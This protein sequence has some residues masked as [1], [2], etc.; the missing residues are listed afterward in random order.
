MEFLHS[1]KARLAAT[2]CEN[3]AVM[4]VPLPTWVFFFLSKTKT[5]MVMNARI[6]HALRACASRLS[7]AHMHFYTLKSHVPVQRMAA[8]KQ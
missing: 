2:Y 1:F 8:V 3:L 4:Q 7:P 6:S 5:Y